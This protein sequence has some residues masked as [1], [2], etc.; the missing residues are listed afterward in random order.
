MSLHPPRAPLLSIALAVQITRELA[1]MTVMGVG[2]ATVTTHT[3]DKTAT[4]ADWTHM[5]HWIGTVL[6]EAAAALPIR[7]VTMPVSSQCSMSGM[8]T[9]WTCC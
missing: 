4:P 5:P 2:Q 8:Q 3:P 6:L 9:S 7:I 1:S